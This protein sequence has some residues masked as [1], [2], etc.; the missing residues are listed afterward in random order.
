MDAATDATRHEKHNDG[1]EGRW[2]GSFVGFSRIIPFTP[3]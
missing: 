3:V 1:R 2:Y